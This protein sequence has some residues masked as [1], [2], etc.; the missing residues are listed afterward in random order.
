MIE[1]TA[2]RAIG[3]NVEIGKPYDSIVE[4]IATT[5]AGSTGQGII[6]DC[7]Q[8]SKISFKF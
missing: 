2:G 1:F 7:P 4:Y 6:V 5:T 8:W 3:G